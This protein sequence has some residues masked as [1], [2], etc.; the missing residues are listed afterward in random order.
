MFFPQSLTLYQIELTYCS[1]S[2]IKQDQIMRFRALLAVWVMCV[3]RWMENQEPL[4][5]D[6]KGKRQSSSEKPW[7]KDSMCNAIKFIWY[8]ILFIILITQRQLISSHGFYCHAGKIHTKE[9]YNLPARNLE[10]IQ[11]E[12]ELSKETPLLPP[13]ILMVFSCPLEDKYLFQRF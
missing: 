11:L 13:V 12:K 9:R 10:W 5:R 2:T 1:N 4:W 6:A 7:P 8:N 3:F